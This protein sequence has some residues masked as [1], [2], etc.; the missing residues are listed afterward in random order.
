V[1]AA[2]VET[3]NL[4]ALD[5]YSTASAHTLALVADKATA[6]NIS[7]NAGVNLTLTGSTKIATLDASAS[8]GAVTATSV[9]TA[10][11][12]MT[13]GSAADSL[14]ANGTTASTLIGGAGADT[15]TTNL[16]LTTLTGGAGNDLFVIGGASANGG[17]YT[18]ISDATAGDRI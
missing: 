5:L 9:S 2:N 6:V 7:G 14:T 17:I 1:T 12:T 16:G 13:G 3:I 15:L 11:I 18:T 4:T 8:T 10:A